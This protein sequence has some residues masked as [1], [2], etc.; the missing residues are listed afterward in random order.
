M[1]HIFPILLTLSALAL[2]QQTALPGPGTSPGPGPAA[3]SP[4]DP[5][6]VVAIV[7]GQPWTAGELERMTGALGGNIQSNFNSNPKGFVETWGL[8]VKLQALAEEE[9]LPE[10]EPHKW[11]LMYN[12]ALYLAQA[13]M[14]AQSGR[15]AILPEE[16]KQYYDEKKDDFGRAKVRVIYLAF[17]D[18]RSDLE[19]EKLAADIVRQARAGAAFPDLVAK[20]SDD[21]DSKAKGGEF[22]PIKPD[23]NTL[24]API[25]SAIFALKPGQISEPVRQPAGYWVFRMEEFVI[26][27]YEEVKDAIFTKLMDRDF[28]AWMEGLRRSVKVEIKDPAYFERRVAQPPSPAPAAAPAKP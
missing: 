23:D 18:K 25:K 5:K 11:R 6:Q 22:P 2:A 14:N 20:Y 10:Q 27:P 8:L 13:R 1:K 15:R 16:Q 26:P 7:E 4:T 17:G 21:K 24:P 9:K 12:R 28:Q 19:T 3:G